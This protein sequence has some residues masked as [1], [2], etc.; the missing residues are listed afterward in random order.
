MSLCARRAGQDIP[1]TV[2]YFHAIVGHDPYPWQR[3]FYTALVRGAVPDAI[4]IPTVSAVPEMLVV[5]RNEGAAF[6]KVSSS[7]SY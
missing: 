6:L 4:D 2:P 3:R 5:G 7:A 1:P